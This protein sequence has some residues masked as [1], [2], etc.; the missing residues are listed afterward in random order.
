MTNLLKRLITGVLLVTLITLSISNGA[1]SFIALILAINLLALL[2]FYNL[3]GPGNIAHRKFYGIG[4][5]FGL[6]LT[7]FFGLTGSSPHLLLL[8]IPLAYAVFIDELYRRDAEP[9]KQ[10]AFTFLGVIWITLPLCL[11]IAT[12]FIK[13]IPGEYHGEIILSYFCL[14]WAHDSFAYISGK[15]LG[16]HPL[17]KSLSPGKTWE[18]SVGGALSSVIIACVISSYVPQLPLTCWVGMAVIII[19]FGTYGDLVKSLLKRSFNIKD[20]G[21]LL[22]GHGGM[23]DRF[24]SLLGSAPF[25]Y[26]YLLLYTSYA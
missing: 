1:Y 15:T 17:F 9:F 13:N 14:L 5:S 3:F 4:L 19:F 18:G 22:P 11:L 21:T 10:L 24:D 25:V 12:V 2:E 7:T 16:K 23:L 8:N 26:T 20:S 6:L